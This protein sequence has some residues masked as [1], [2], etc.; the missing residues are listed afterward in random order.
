MPDDPIDEWDSTPPKAYKITRDK[1][2]RLGI[3][4][5]A[6]PVSEPRRTGITIVT[7]IVFVVTFTVAFLLARW[8][9]P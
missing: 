9:L 5:T 3:K 6:P 2:G 8:L 4:Y 7:V 1:G